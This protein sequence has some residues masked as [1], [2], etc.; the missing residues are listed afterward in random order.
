MNVLPSVKA[1]VN[2]DI[3]RNDHRCLPRMHCPAAAIS[4]AE[5][6]MYMKIDEEKCIGCGKCIKVCKNN[7]LFL[8][9]QE[10]KF[11]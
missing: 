2:L 7:A 8:V 9:R 11:G 5:G 10:V 3:C 1:R 4:P 6:K